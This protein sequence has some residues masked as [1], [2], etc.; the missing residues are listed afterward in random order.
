MK[1]TFLSL[2]HEIGHLKTEVPSIDRLHEKNIINEGVASFL[3]KQPLKLWLGWENHSLLKR[4]AREM[5]LNLSTMVGSK[6]REKLKLEETVKKIPNTKKANRET[7]LDA[8]ASDL[9]DGS[10]DEDSDEDAPTGD[11]GHEAIETKEDDDERSPIDEELIDD[12]DYSEFKDNQKSQLEEIRLYLC[13]L[14]APDS[15]L[16]FD[17]RGMESVPFR[18]RWQL[19]S[20]WRRCY[21]DAVGESLKNLED[22]YKKDIS[23]YKMLKGQSLA[24]LCREALVV[25]MTTTGAA[26]NRK[27]LEGL[28]CKIGN[29]DSVNFVY[30]S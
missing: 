15:S 11:V 19:F 10:S 4:I 22:N 20:Y 23:N 30:I 29:F 9:S 21:R 24:A 1:K 26:K 5:R 16:E 7:R 2:K 28:R 18:K 17:P 25:G 14:F 27:M 13:N 8:D 12:L 3:E 6:R